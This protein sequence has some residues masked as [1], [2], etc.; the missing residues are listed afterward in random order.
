M[1]STNGL[2]GPGCYKS[3]QSNPATVANSVFACLVHLTGKKILK[4]RCNEDVAFLSGDE[5]DTPG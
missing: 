4:L 5:H 1:G 3:Y 2:V